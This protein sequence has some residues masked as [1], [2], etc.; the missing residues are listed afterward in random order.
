MHAG[1]R[2]WLAV[3]VGVVLS[4]SIAAPAS[5]G[6]SGDG[7][8]RNGD[9]G[10][11]AGNGETSTGSAG[12][13][14]SGEGG[15]GS[16][17]GCTYTALD[18]KMSGYA[19]SLGLLGLGETRG[20]GAGAWFRKVCPD[21]TA[22]VVWIPTR[23]PAVDPAVLAQQA[24]DRTTIPRP[25]IG[26][27]PPAGADQVVNVPTWLWVDNFQPVSATASAGPVTVTVVAKPVRSDWTMGTGDTVTC[28][29][30]GTP[31]DRRRLPEAQRTGCSYTYRRSS[32]SRPTGAYELRAT[33][34]WHVTWT[35]K[36][37]SASGDFGLVNRS[38]DVAVRVA[39]IQALHG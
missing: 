22:T 7:W 8:V 31:Y 35:A 15:G 30:A 9:I 3:P 34:V 27:N 20:P 29:G 2:R 25:G 39:E 6:A 18:Q 11:I 4:I 21:G 17:S 1:M 37:V 10:A 38:G 32:A 26:L 28:A 19:D 24:Y 36:G 23:A 5:A 33:T 13:G 12:G 14:G 16:S